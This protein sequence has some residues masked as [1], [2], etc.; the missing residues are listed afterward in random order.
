M[1]FVRFRLCILHLPEQEP[2]EDRVLQQYMLQLGL[3]RWYE[4]SD[5]RLWWA[6][7]CH[8]TG[9]AIELKADLGW[10][11]SKPC[12][13]VLMVNG[14]LLTNE[15]QS[16]SSIILNTLYEWCIAIFNVAHLNWSIFSLRFVPLNDHGTWTQ[17][18]NMNISGWRAW[19]WK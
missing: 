4:E 12:I 17:W 10:L 16:A 15:F 8:Q 6:C 7:Y 14:I 13:P 1:N 19:F 11:Y 18:P 3:C 5:L 2:M 9:I